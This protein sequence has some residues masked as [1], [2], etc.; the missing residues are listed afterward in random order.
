V[1][2]RTPEAFR[3]DRFRAYTPEELVAMAMRPGSD[4]QDAQD[5]ATRDLL[6]HALCV[7]RR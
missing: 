7:K 5:K 3:R 2:E 6:D 1:Q 4:Q